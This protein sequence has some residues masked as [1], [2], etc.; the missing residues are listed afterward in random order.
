V[1]V[2]MAITFY[3]R[4]RFCAFFWP[5]LLMPAAYISDIFYFQCLTLTESRADLF[6]WVTLLSVWLKNNQSGA[7]RCPDWLWSAFEDDIHTII[8]RNCG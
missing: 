5:W 6:L 2:F 3:N 4:S 8:H 7:G 1:A